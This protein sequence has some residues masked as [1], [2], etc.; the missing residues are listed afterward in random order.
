MPE[1]K[2]IQRYCGA[3]RNN[4]HNGDN[5]AR[6]SIRMLALELYR[7]MKLIEELEKKLESQ[8]VGSR[9][10]GELQKKLREARAEK[11]RLKKMMEG[12]KGD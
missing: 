9:E 8:E 6:M 3:S 12:A 5:V 2:P 7:V 10:R 11:D 4:L 1:G